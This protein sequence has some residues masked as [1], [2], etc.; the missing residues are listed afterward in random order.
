MNDAR[1]VALLEQGRRVLHAQAFSRLVGAELT[2]FEAGRAE[3]RIPVRDELKQQNG[4]VHGGV[5]AYLADNS[6]TYAGGSVLGSSV[7][8]SEFK[9]N[10]AKPAIGEVLIARASVVNAGKRQ[11]VCRC[12]IFVVAGGRENLCA[13]AQGTIVP[14]GDKSAG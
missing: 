6:L 13:A 2:V 12:D 7:V 1:N 9:I 14:L 8:T 3:I 5:L 4:F 10:Y 11:A